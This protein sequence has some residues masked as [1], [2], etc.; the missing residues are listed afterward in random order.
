MAATRRTGVADKK[1]Q[2]L[3]LQVGVDAVERLLIHSIKTKMSPGELVTKLIEDHLRQWKI[4]INSQSNTATRN[5]PVMISES[6]DSDDQASLS[7]KEAA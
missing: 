7:K 5:A 1:T 6:E 4:Q 2:R 3:N